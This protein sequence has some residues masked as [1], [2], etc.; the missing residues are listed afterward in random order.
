MAMGYR[1][2]WRGVPLARCDEI[3]RTADLVAADLEALPGYTAVQPV[4]RAASAALGNYGFLGPVSDPASI[5]RGSSAFAA[6]AALSRELELA[7]EDDGRAIPTDFID[8]IDWPGMEPPFFA[9]IAWGQAGAQVPARVDP[10]PS[11]SGN[12][13]PDL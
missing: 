5:T 12:H 7:A 9:W 10:P 1:I 6:A 3:P 8:L 2:L 11:R 4:V 13:A